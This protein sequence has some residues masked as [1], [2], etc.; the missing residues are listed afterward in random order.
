MAEYRLYNQCNCSVFDFFQG[1]NEPKQTKGLGFILA[2]NTAA[3]KLFLKLIEVNINKSS[4]RKND[5]LKANLIVD[6]ELPDNSNAGS[7]NKKGNRIDILL[8][9][10]SHDK[11]P[12]FA[13]VIEAKSITVKAN[14]LKVDLQLERY[15]NSYAAF[16]YD[17]QGKILPVTLSQNRMPADKYANISWLQLLNIFA[18]LNLKSI[19]TKEKGL[20]IDYFNFLTK[21]LKMKD[22]IKFYEKEILTIPAKDESIKA[23]EDPDCAIYE[24]PVNTKYNK[25]NK[26]ALYL[27]FR[28]KGKGEMTEL[29]KVQEIIIV[30]FDDVNGWSSL[31]VDQQK[32][33]NVYNNIQ[34]RNGLKRVFFLDKDATIE[35]PNPVYP[36]NNGKGMAGAATYTL[37]DFLAK[38]D[39][40]GCVIL[41]KVQPKLLKD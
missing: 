32:R 4:I 34:P 12:I 28:K 40:N 25:Y 17:F 31:S 29:Y 15:L 11:K 5:L 3:L 20:I 30:D 41:P 9:F 16:L 23:I 36:Y 18:P 14:A 7:G 33:L 10:Y 1:Q 37:S 26:N 27:A 6:C 8:R 24:C 35:L 39:S 19:S 22:S 2:K 38:P 21:I 13:I